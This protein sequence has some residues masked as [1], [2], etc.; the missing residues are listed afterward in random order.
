MSVI[1]ATGS[2]TKTLSPGEVRAI[3]EIGAGVLVADGADHRRAGG[4]IRAHGAHDAVP[5]A[6]GAGDG[7]E[8]AVLLQGAA[9]GAGGVGGGGG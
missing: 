8:L 9:A 3:Q 1:G 7:R 5:D 6:V 4:A 2:G